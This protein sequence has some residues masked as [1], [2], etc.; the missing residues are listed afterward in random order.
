M[1]RACVQAQ[2]YGALGDGCTLNTRALQAAI[3][4]AALQGAELRVGPGVYLTGA[5]FLKSGMT[6]RLERG[7]TLLGSRDLADYPLLPT[8]VAG[9][10]MRW[11]AALVNIYGEQDVALL[12]EG[13][14]DGDGKVFWDSYWALRATYEPRGLRWASDYDC[15]RPRLVQVFESARIT[16]GEGLLLRRS[17]FWTLHLCYSEDVTV[18]RVTIRNNEDAHGPSTDGIDIDSSRRVT[19]R[20]ADIA[21]ND[22]ALC[23]KAGRDA[24]GLRVARV[25]E[26]IHISDCIVREGAAGLTFGS[27]TSGGLRRINAQ[28]IA[29]HAPVPVGLLFKSAPT[30]GGFVEDVSISDLSLHGV[31][32]AMRAT[33]NWN[34][35]YSQA[36]IPDAERLAAPPHWLALARPVPRE[37]GRTRVE[38]V[39]IQRLTARGARVAF[40]VDATAEVPLRRFD[41]RG[42]AIE[43]Q[44]GGH[45]QDALGWHF[46]DGC[47][48]QLGTPITVGSSCQIAGLPAAHCRVDAELQRR[49]VSALPMAE[50]DVQ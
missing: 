36:Q 12:G 33:M 37:Q 39:R 19:I 40:E 10:E 44:S 21:V 50:Q 49:D 22:D 48:L 13:C 15:Q 34:P 9:I 16:I 28:R 23:L 25:C 31:P 47:Q 27:E 18:D 1:T 42:I 29:V 45:V 26:D 14:I 17:G 35:A 2:A 6:L 32:V 5:L 46:D 3:D 30:R 38:G 8:R 41:F 4:S 20:H 43:A 11:P 7:A 24:D